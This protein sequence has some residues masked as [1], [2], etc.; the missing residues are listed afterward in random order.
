MALLATPIEIQQRALDLLGAKL[1][2]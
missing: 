1:K 2:L